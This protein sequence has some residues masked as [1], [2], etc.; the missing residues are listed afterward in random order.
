MKYQ[1]I[2]TLLGTVILIIIAA[3]AAGFVLICFKNYP[4]TYNISKIVIPEELYRKTIFEKDPCKLT[5]EEKEELYSEIDIH[6]NQIAS[7]VIYSN[8]EKGIQSI[9]LGK[10]GF[11]VND[12]GS[13]SFGKWSNAAPCP[14]LITEYT[15]IF[16]E[17]RNKDEIIA[18]IENREWEGEEISEGLKMKSVEK[19][20]SVD[21]VIW[22]EWGPY[23]SYQ[24]TFEIPGESNNI[25]IKTNLHLLAD[26][27]KYD[28][29]V[30]LISTLN[31]AERTDYV[32]N[33]IWDQLMLEDSK[34]SL[35]DRELFHITKVSD[36][37]VIALG[38]VR[39]RK[40]FGGGGANVF[41]YRS[42][43]AEEWIVNITQEGFYCSDL[44]K[45]SGSQIDFI[46][47]NYTKKCV[48]W[49]ENGNMHENKIEGIFQ[50]RDFGK[51]TV[52]YPQ[53]WYWVDYDMQFDGF[54]TN[55]KNLKEPWISEISDGDVKLIFSAAPLNPV[56]ENIADVTERI[57]F[58]I[59]DYQNYK[60]EKYQNF[61][62]SDYTKFHSDVVFECH[63][64]DGDVFYRSI[65]FGLENLSVD[66]NAVQYDVTALSKDPDLIEMFSVSKND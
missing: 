5:S 66:N 43:P 28:E 59:Q 61:K 54:V 3:T 63:Y 46:L 40:E 50:N 4:V 62:C 52:S 23:P 48:E 15:L 38:Y 2:S 41:A 37:E 35:S 39:N 1:K 19:I 13:V 45:F 34:R 9:N 27:E 30:E 17:K 25:I 26:Q 55:N 21:V 8:P 6:N 65:Q 32:E 31:F 53:T 24:Y 33:E 11:I 42:T 36:D 16:S 64:D 10:H 22:E 47:E 18:D 20:E 12:D 14:G 7:E 56:S 57:K 44:S 29:I 51:F 58:E 49:D 60:K